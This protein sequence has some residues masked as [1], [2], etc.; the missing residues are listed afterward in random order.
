MRLASLSLALAVTLA[1]GSASS[2]A[3][4]GCASFAWDLSSER[5]LL[6]E[7]GRPSLSS[8]ARI[9]ASPPT[10]FDLVLVRSGAAGLPKPPERT[11]RAGAESWAGY[12]TVPVPTAGTYRVTLPA[13]AWIDVIQGGETVTSQAFT[14]ARDCPGVRKSVAFQL[15]AG[16]ATVQ[17]SGVAVEKLSVALT[18]ER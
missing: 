7:A 15:R 14:S 12:V 4:S 16:P 17:L 11:R 3:E 10:A 2:A 13:E 8:G 1:A 9:D 5:V 6:G 18:R